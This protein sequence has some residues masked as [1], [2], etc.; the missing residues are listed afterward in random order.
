[1]RVDEKWMKSGRKVDKWIS[2]F[3]STFVEVD[4]SGQ[5]WMRVN[6]SG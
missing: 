4:E 5:E 1:M 2:G 6:E 3:S